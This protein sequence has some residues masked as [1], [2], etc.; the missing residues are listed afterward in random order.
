MTREMQLDGEKVMLRQLASALWLLSIPRKGA[1]SSRSTPD[2]HER[3]KLPSS[4]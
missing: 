1:G 3:S 2:Y 4:G